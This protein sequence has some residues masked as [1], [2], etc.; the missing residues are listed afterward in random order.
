[1][2]INETI[3]ENFKISSKDI[4]Y[5]DYA[6]T[7]FMPQQVI[8]KWEDY[9][10]EIGIFYGKGNNVLAEQAADS[11]KNAENVIHRH[12]DI[13]YN[14]EFVYGKNTTEVINVIA[15]GM[16]EIVKP[17]DYIL[18]GPYEHHSNLLPWKYL[19]KKKGAVFLEMPLKSNGDIDWDYLQMIK[20]NIKIVSFSSVSNTNGYKVDVDKICEIL[21][22]S[23]IFVDESQQTAHDKIKTNPYIAG[24]F[25]TSHKM[26]GPKNIAGAL[27]SK[28]LLEKLSPVLLGGGMVNAIGFEDTWGDYKHKFEAGTLDIGLICAWAEACRFMDSIGFDYI[29]ELEKYCYTKVSEVLEACDNIHII[30]NHNGAD[31]LVS[32]VSKEIHAHDIEYM[33]AKKNIIIRSGNLCAQPSVR[34]FGELAVNRISFG[35]G[36]SENALNQLCAALKEILKV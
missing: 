27:V 1:M 23:Y 30:D 18:V 29:K 25:M 21:K 5:F 15:L 11:M 8:Q 14:Y 35:L 22:K 26:Y 16:D 34:K 20:D 9:H 6:A 19:A 13:D 28:N 36:V 12:F 33:L 10:N 2:N 7:T 32:F 24:Y 3:I 17:M 4:I 31:S